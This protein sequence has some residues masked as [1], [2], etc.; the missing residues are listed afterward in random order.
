MIPS[1]VSVELEELIWWR[2]RLSFNNGKP[3]HNLA[4]DLITESDASWERVWS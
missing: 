4:P 1:L 3:I 2:D